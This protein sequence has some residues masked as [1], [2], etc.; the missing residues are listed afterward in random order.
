[1]AQHQLEQPATLLPLQLNGNELMAGA[2]LVVFRGINPLITHKPGPAHVMGLKAAKEA[3]SQEDAPL[4]RVGFTPCRSDLKICQS[5]AESM[6]PI[7][8]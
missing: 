6:Q 7:A 8:A 4:G 3:T 2:G 5:A 1:M